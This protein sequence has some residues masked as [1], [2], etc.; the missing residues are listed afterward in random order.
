MTTVLDTAQSYPGFEPLSDADFAR[1]MDE[2]VVPFV[3]RLRKDHRLKTENGK[4]IYLGS[5][6][7]KGTRSYRVVSRILRILFQIR[8]IYLLYFAARLRAVSL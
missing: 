6:C 4:D 2:R 7:E 5:G 8:R 3:N 1:D